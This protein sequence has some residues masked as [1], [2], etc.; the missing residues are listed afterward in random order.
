MILYHVDRSGHLAT[1]MKIDLVKNFEK[2]VPEYYFECL[3]SHGVHYYL[4]DFKSKDDTLEAVFEYEK[5]LH[6]SDKFS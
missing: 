5:R 2:L 4:G 6:Y 3:S 1:G